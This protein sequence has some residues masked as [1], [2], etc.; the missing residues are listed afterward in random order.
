MFV[1]I[2]KYVKPLAEVDVV[3]AAHFEYLDRYFKEGKFICA[4]RQ[5]PPVGGLIVC[6][7][8]GIDEVRAIVDADPYTQA[9]VAEYQVI[10]FTPSRFAEGFEKFI[11]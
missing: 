5:T 10:E 6:N 2:V 3:R 11:G 9:G 7:A 4:G 1:L 8:A